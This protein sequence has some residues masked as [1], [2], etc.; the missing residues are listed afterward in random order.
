MN[1]LHPADAV[2]V[3]VAHTEY[4]QGGWPLIVR[5]LRGGNGVVL[6]VKSQLDRTKRPDCIELWR[7]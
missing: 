1:A 3:A 4:R 5:L 2:I 6:D 7:L